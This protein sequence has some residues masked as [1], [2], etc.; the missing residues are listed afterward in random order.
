M[1]RYDVGTDSEDDSDEE[2]AK[3]SVRLHP[4]SVECKCD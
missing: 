2:S 4:V 3:T 1:E